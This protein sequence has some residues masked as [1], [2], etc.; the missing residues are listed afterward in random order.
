MP[1]VCEFVRF[2]C[3]VTPVAEVFP[4]AAV[5]ADTFVDDAVEV[6]S[7]EAFFVGVGEGDAE[8]AADEVGDFTGVAVVPG[9]TVLD[10]DGVAVGEVGLDAVVVVADLVAGAVGDAPDEVGDASVFVFAGVAA[11]VA[12]AD[13]VAFVASAPFA[14]GVADREGLAFGDA[15]GDADGLAVAGSGVL[16]LAAG[17][18]LALGVA[19]ALDEAAGEAATVA[20][21]ECVLV[22]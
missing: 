19:L 20:L 21:A 17:E 22:D 6:G 13:G 12:D 2:V 9:W 10:A 11:V 16:V 5:A 1:V 14:S 3:S 4:L 8:R 7:T 15:E 18:V